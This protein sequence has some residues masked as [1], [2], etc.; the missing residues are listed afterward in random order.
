MANEFALVKTGRWRE[1][2]N[3]DWERFYEKFTRRSDVIIDG[4]RRQMQTL[5]GGG[6]WRIEKKPKVK[7]C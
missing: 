6:V 3:G 7:P 5:I 4:K 1:T 2:P